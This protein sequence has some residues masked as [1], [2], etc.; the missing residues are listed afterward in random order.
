MSLKY[1][2]NKLRR[3]L[4]NLLFWKNIYRTLKHEGLGSFKTKA[5]NFIN[6]IN[7]YIS[8]HLSYRYI[9]PELTEEIKVTLQTLKTQPLIS[10]IMPVYNVEPK[11][12]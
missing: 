4:T 10:I 11:W 6:P 9:T 5:L 12:L 2:I 1:S 8:P 3:A 7:R